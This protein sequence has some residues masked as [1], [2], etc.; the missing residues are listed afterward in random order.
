VVATG[1]LP[2]DSGEPTD[3]P[4]APDAPG[5]VV[6]A[7]AELAAVGLSPDEHPAATYA[8]AA[9]IGTIMFRLSTRPRLRRPTAAAAAGRVRQGRA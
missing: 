9:T 5:A 2:P 8:A 7:D 6:L 3:A 4:D 1:V